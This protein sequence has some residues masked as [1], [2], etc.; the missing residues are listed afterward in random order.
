[1]FVEDAM[2]TVIPG[3]HEFT[4]KYIFPR[5]GRIRSTAHVLASL[6]T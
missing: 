1:V 4:L 3:G 2:S 6:T 5:M